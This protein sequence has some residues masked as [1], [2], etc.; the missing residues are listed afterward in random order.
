M[1]RGLLVVVISPP[2][3]PSSPLSALHFRLVKHPSLVFIFIFI[4][5]FI[6]RLLALDG[7]WRRLS[8][9][10]DKLMAVLGPPSFWV[11]LTFF[12]STPLTSRFHH[13]DSCPQGQWSI[14]SALLRYV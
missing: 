8:L 1:F 7:W 12:P 10:V 2:L 9:T 4:F 11:P 14:S 5:I 3:W 6:F 13:F